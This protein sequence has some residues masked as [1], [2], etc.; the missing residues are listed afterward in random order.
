M[1]QRPSPFVGVIDRRGKGWAKRGQGVPKVMRVRREEERAGDH[2][3]KGRSPV[4][5]TSPQKSGGRQ[6]RKDRSSWS[7]KIVKI[8]F[9]INRAYYI[10]I[11][12]TNKILEKLGR[13]SL[14]G[15]LQPA[16]KE[17]LVSL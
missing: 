13:P 10:D 12:K 3:G 16:S 2:S 17:T 9:W 6:G 4:E 5:R 15:Q 11:Y 8:K 7:L 14:D 1:V